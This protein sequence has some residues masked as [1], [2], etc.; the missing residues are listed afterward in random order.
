MGIHNIPIELLLLMVEKL[1]MKELS[2]FLSTCWRLWSL[3]TPYFHDLGMQD[4]GDLTALQWAAQNGHA[5][6]AEIAIKGGADIEKPSQDPLGRG[7]MHM[8]AMNNHPAIIH[9]L[10]KNHANISA[11]DN[12]HFTPLHYAVMCKAGLE[13]IKVLLELG[14]EMMCGNEFVDAPPFFAAQCGSVS[15]MKVFVDEGFN[16]TTRGLEG[17]N[18]LH[19]AFTKNVSP[20]MVSYLLSK[21]EVKPLM[22]VQDSRGIAPLPNT[23]NTKLLMLQLYLRAFF[24]R[25]RER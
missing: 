8:A 21:E 17:K 1:S 23:G 7:P 19:H 25:D 4:V 10:V 11:R 22:K 6:L 9:L 5:S 12:C 16:L 18:I 13:T 20:E 15:C 3:L 2:Y 24:G 14:A